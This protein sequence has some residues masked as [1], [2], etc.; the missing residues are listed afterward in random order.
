MN[1]SVANKQIQITKANGELEYFDDEKFVQSL[2]HAGVDGKTAHILLSEIHQVL[3]EGMHTH[4]IYRKAFKM[5]KTHSRQSAARY[6]LKRAIMDLGPS[7]YPFER[8]VASI[9]K[10]LGYEVRVGEIIRG[11]CVSHEVDVIAWNKQEC[12]LIECKFHNQAGHKND[13]KIPLYV[14]SRFEDIA[15]NE[16]Q[17]RAAL[18][19]PLKYGLATN[20]RFTKDAIQYASCNQMN[21]I[22]WDYPASSSL[23]A[24]IA[25]TQLHPLT[26]LTRLSAKAKDYLLEKECITCS[27]ILNRQDILVDYGMSN[28]KI[29]ALLNEINELILSS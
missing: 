11:H 4:A 2:I 26:C 23:K 3:R 13:I 15:L 1:N 25:E 29:K 20:T 14:K 17:E 12:I 8:L 18:K 22:S 5:L 9:Y 28:A 7:G 19:L 24:L 21:V 27:D 10:R 6:N 16:A